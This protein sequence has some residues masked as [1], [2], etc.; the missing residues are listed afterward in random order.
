MIFRKLSFFLA[1]VGIASSLSF[2][3]TGRDTLPGKSLNDYETRIVG[4]TEATEGQWPWI[5][6]MV[7]SDATDN[8]NGQFCGGTL[9][10]PRYI[11]TAAHCVEDL[12]PEDLNVVL[13]L[14]RL[15]DPDFETFDVVDIIVHPRWDTYLSN[16]DVALLL[17]DRPAIGFET[18]PLVV[19]NSPLDD[20]GVVATAIGW[21][22]ND[23]EATTFPVEL[24]TVDLP[25]L[26]TAVVNGANSYN[27]AITVDMLAAGFM[28][29][30]KD[31]CA[32]DSGAPLFVSDGADGHV[33][34]GITSWGEGCAEPNF[35]GIYTRVGVFRDW[36]LS[37]ILPNYYSWEQEKGLSGELLDIDGDGFTAL[38]EFSL[39]A[40]PLD[41]TSVPTV[42]FSVRETGS[43]TYPVIEYAKRLEALE[44]DYT[45]E[46]ASAVNDMDRLDLGVNSVAA[47]GASSAG[48]EATAVRGDSKID[49]STSYF[50]RVN[51][52]ISGE[53]TPT[54]F[55]ITPD[56]NRRSALQS[57]DDA[58]PLISGRYKKDY[59]LGD[60]QSG[61]TYEL[62]L[63]SGD[64]DAY[65][66]LLNADTLEV[67]DQDDNDGISQNSSLSF[68]PSAG[69][70]YIARVTSAS[71]AETGRFSL[72]LS[73][74]TVFP[75]E[76][77]VGALSSSD[78]LD[79]LYLPDE[80]YKDDYLIVAPENGKTLRIELRAVFDAYLE[81]VDPRD[82][83]LILADDD[84]GEG[85]DG[86]DSL[87]EI[88][89]FSSSQLMVRVTSANP[90][91]TGSYTLVVA[92]LP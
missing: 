79:P 77:I 30:G 74:A 47:V 64:F 42:D 33:L 12:E 89:Y 18:L 63:L 62:S 27:G 10:H 20:V 4:G 15:D 57:E 61:T 58:N 65:L 81:I 70:N 80:F 19:E 73:E 28:S 87:L 38:A 92:E 66:Q 29:G 51:A 23:N 49:D 41:S 68:T 85:N 50:M 34:V 35:P 32:G 60:L 39:G 24:R 83:A 45:V 82:G 55:S 52:S 36:V 91:E 13:G 8:Y 48:Y 54:V 25:I 3:S 26:G 75:G 67:I 44:I 9:V 86:L 11:L 21:G 5:A 16:S 40:D 37:H 14:H 2:A 31:S 22:A 88:Q 78:D 59:K 71:L 46:G 76:S 1:F 17:L 7:Y 84:G 53:Y 56:S 90:K 43:G 6:A 72:A 69:V